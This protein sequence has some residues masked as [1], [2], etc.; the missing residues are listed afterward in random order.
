MSLHS[1]LRRRIGTLERLLG[2]S[3]RQFYYAA[4]LVYERSGNGVTVYDITNSN[5]IK[6]IGH[7]AAGGFSEIISL[8]G[9]RVALAGDRLHILD[10]S[11]RVSSS[12][13]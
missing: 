6:R 3:Y 12:A 13:R 11:E 4:G 8:P 2:F 10:L 5:R 1:V 9:N 7:Y